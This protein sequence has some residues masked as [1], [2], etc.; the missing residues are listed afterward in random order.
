[1]LELVDCRYTY[2]Y[3]GGHIDGAHNIYTEEQLVE[4]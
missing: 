1:M 3:E 2:E 4:R